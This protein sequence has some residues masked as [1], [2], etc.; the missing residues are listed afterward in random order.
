MNKYE[1]KALKIL[2][3]KKLLTRM[4]WYNLFHEYSSVSWHLFKFKIVSKLVND[5]K[6]DIIKDYYYIKESKTS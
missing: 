4:Q 2:S 1:E 5:G 3:Q 6:V